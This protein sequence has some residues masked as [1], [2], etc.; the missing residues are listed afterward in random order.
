MITFHSRQ[1]DCAR[2]A[3]KN[4]NAGTIN[5]TSQI[6][7]SICT[8]EFT[9]CEKFGATIFTSQ[10]SRLSLVCIFRQVDALLLSFVR[11]SQLANGSPKIAR[12]PARRSRDGRETSGKKSGKMSRIIFAQR[13]GNGRTVAVAM[14]LNVRQDD[15]QDDWPCTGIRRAMSTPETCA[16]T[17][18]RFCNSRAVVCTMVNAASRERLAE[19][20]S[21]AFNHNIQR[22]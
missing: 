14:P 21:S 6:A 17:R 16:T 1:S 5:F 19:F 11:F 12:S 4:K 7:S 15:L 3:R 20:S 13:P 22:L 10:R 8:V 9:K 2:R 18:T